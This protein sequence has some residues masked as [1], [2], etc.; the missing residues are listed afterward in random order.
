MQEDAILVNVARGPI[1]QEAA[2]YEHLTT[3]PNFSAGLDVWWTEPFS[4]EP[5]VLNFP[6]LDLPNVIGTPH[7]SAIA[8]DSLVV[9]ARRAAENVRRFLKREPLHGL[10]RREDYLDW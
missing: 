1:L 5:L 6:F 10:V 8:G 3:H 4:D 2:L 9:G 7:T